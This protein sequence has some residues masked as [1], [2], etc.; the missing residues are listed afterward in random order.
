MLKHNLPAK[1]FRLVAVFLAIAGSA[2]A[3]QPSNDLD[4]KL[5]EPGGAGQGG[6]TGAKPQAA[7]PGAP[8]SWDRELGAA[9]ISEDQQPLVDV[10]QRMRFIEQRMVRGDCGPQTQQSQQQVVA[11]LDRL[12]RQARSQAQAADSKQSA[13]ATSRPPSGDGQTQ[14][15][16]AK[17]GQQAKPGRQ[18]GT[19]AR[20]GGTGADRP[21]A[22]QLSSVFGQ[23]WGELP[24]Q[25]RQQLLQQWSAEQF[26]PE[27]APLVEQY[28]RR[29]TEAQEERR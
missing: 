10:A 24:E 17:P 26:L 16:G 18:P 4:R 21:R 22:G 20:S 15:A 2:L 7:T 19:A 11:D 29:L 5:F 23:A 8:R 28:F 12:I 9:A 13:T 1:T 3:A 27:Y 6:A 25:A 14:A